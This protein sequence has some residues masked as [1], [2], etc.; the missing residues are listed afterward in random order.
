MKLKFLLV[1]IFIFIF[2]LGL[3]FKP[4]LLYLNFKPKKKILILTYS[5]LA[6]CGKNT[7]LSLKKAGFNCDIYI[8]TKHQFNYLLQGILF[9]DLKKCYSN[10][11]N[12]YEIDLNIYK[13]LQKK[14]YKYDIILLNESLFLKNLKKRSN[15][16]IGVIHGGTEYRVNHNLLNNTFNKIV[17]ITIIR[18][19][20]LYNV[21]AKNSKLLINPINLDYFTPNFNFKN[22]TKLVIDHSPSNTIVKGTSLILNVIND[23][24]QNDLYNNKFIYIGVN[25]LDNNK[26]TQNWDK[27]IKKYL[28]CDIY[29]ETVNPTINVNYIKKKSWDKFKG[30]EYQFGE[31]GVTC[32]EACASG[33]IVLTNTFTENL[34]YKYY[35]IKPKIIICNDE[36]SLKNNLIKLIN[37]NREDLFKLKQ[38]SYDWVKNYHDLNYHGKKLGEYLI[39]L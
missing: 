30:K 34:Y 15:Q 37:M 28:K 8:G 13:K 21:G 35:K 31:W 19:G 27:Q 1:L 12:H 39:K 36:T 25:S 9:K 32:L 33:C 20:D 7:Q 2:F 22:N 24:K 38:K 23:L 6:N 10:K 18:T 16:K 11:N 26:H 4:I 29:I 5:D 14:I 17:D 3:N